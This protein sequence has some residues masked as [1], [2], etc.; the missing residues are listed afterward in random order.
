MGIGTARGT[1]QYTGENVKKSENEMERG[2]LPA[3]YHIVKQNTRC[4][5]GFHSSG[6]PIKWTYY[7]ICRTSVT[8]MIHFIHS[9]I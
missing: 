1:E 3:F 2:Q 4:M 7:I 6:E 8:G 5:Y 9:F